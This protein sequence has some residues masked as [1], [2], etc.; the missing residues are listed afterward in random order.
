MELVELT[1][2]EKVGNIKEF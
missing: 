1:R 2:A